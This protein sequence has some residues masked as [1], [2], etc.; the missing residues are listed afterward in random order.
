MT[1]FLFL[2]F[3][4]HVFTMVLEVVVKEKVSTHCD[5]SCGIDSCE[6]EKCWWKW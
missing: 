5:G 4:P 1:H 6:R 3:P 2:F